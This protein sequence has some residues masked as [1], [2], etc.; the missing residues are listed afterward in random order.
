MCGRLN[1]SYDLRT[2]RNYCSYKIP[3]TELAQLKGQGHKV[4]IIVYTRK[5]HWSVHLQRT[6]TETYLVSVLNNINL[7]QQQ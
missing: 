1:W 4:I 5:K 6:T 7:T 2:L 3:F